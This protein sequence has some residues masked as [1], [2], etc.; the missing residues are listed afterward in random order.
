MNPQDRITCT[1]ANTTKLK[2]INCL[3]ESVMQ[4]ACPLSS[5]L[6]GM[7]KIGNKPKVV[8]PKNR[9]RLKKIN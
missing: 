9:K 6:P 4:P 8:S 2:L 5:A 1:K 7:R 3:S